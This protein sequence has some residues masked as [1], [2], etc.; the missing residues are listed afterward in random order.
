MPLCRALDSADKVVPLISLVAVG[1][2]ENMYL[3]MQPPQRPLAGIDL[4]CCFT[5]LNHRRD[6]SV[7]VLFIADQ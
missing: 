7:E 6:H 4:D 5:R 1:L 3:R 2:D